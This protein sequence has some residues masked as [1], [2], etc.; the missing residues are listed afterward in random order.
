MSTG[1]ESMDNHGH[2]SSLA[3]STP[4]AVPGTLP[5]QPDAVTIRRRKPLAWVF[6][7]LFLVVVIGAASWFVW[8]FFAIR[9]YAGHDQ[10]QP[11]DAIAVFGAAE[12]D[13]RPSPTLRVRLDHALT[14]Y[15]RGLA[16]MIITLGGQGDPY[17]SE[18]SVGR[19]YLMAN[20]VPESNIIAETRSNN[21][22]S[23]AAQLAVIARANELHT[24][25]AVSDGTHLFRIRALCLRKG[26]DVFT[27]P[28]PP[29]RPISR[30]K[31]FERMAHEMLSYTLWRIG[32]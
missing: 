10:A 18:G 14:L 11:A 7:S 23:S 25:L 12:Y 32:L 26:L 24:I 2:N 16:P 29:G 9:F 17:H 19:D 21:T 6:A 30:K 22:E 31:R 13:G 3:P 28:H 5:S 20:G 8:L 27:S 4:D 15:R 1:T